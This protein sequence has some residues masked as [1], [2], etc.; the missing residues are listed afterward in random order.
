MDIDPS[1]IAAL[2]VFFDKYSYYTT[3]ELAQMVDRSPSTIRKWRKKC[4]RKTEKMPFA[5]AK[6][7][8][9]PT[10]N[11]PSVS[12]PDIWDNKEWFED[13]YYNDGYGIPT[14]AKII[15]RSVS[16]VVKRFERYGIQTRSYRES[17]ASKNPCCCPQWLMENY[18]DREQYLEWCKQNGKV[19]TADGGKGQTLAECA[20]K[21]DV[22][23]YTIYNWLVK[24]RISIRD[25]NEAM[26]GKRNPFYGRKHSEET[27]R[28]IREAQQKRNGDTETRSE[29]SDTTTAT[30]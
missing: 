9:P 18:A 24:F 19:P 10:R 21:A 11:I 3:Y 26:V 25:I 2:S 28:K 14:I 22:V 17:M 27:K 29:R 15:N 6:K 5:N 13:K 12:S 30:V 4:N 20:V 23:P 16:L 8:T 1:D 7:P